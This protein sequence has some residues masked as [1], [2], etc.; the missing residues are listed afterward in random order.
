MCLL[1]DQFL[2]Y[3]QSMKLKPSLFQL[4]V[5]LMT[6]SLL[7]SCT[8]NSNTNQSYCNNPQQSAQ[9]AD[10][11]DHSSG[12]HS[13]SRHRSSTYRSKSGTSTTK[14]NSKVG[15]GGFGSFGSGSRVSG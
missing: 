6:V 10:D 14:S 9:Q 13:S 3:T 15:R 4:I 8:T 11:C 2:P 5:V 12:G 1:I 7:A